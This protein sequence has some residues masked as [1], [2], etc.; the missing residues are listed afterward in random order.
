LRRRLG[1]TAGLL[2]LAG[3]G[4]AVASELRHRRTFLADPQ[5]RL[6]SSPLGGH[7]VPA[8]SADGTELHVEVFGTGDSPTFV[9]IPGWTEEL[10]IFD[11]VTRELLRRGF[12]VVSYDPRGQGSS[13]G[14]RELDQSIERYAEDLTAVLRA[15]CGGRDDVIVAG[16]S[17]GGMSLV[18]WAELVDVSAFVRAVALVSTG[19]SGLVDGLGLLTASIPLE[20]RRALLIP[21]LAG[22]QPMIAYSTPLSRAINRY[23]MFG[24][25]ATA[26]HIAFVE[27]MIWRMHG[28]LRA[29]AAVTMRDLDLSSA[30][31]R[32]NVPALV[33]VGD[34][35]RLTPPVHARRMVSAL[36][37]VAEF[38]LLKRTGHMVP[39][40]RPL[41]LAD[42]LVGL[43]QSVGMPAPESA[44]DRSAADKT[45]EPQ[46]AT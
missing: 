25:D 18:G 12:R 7:P 37:Q 32:V 38:V 43:A 33:V 9:L 45:A 13:G 35:D 5:W 2:T 23:V 39:V 21:L 20:T 6:L 14:G 8:R 44:A 28:K 26:A 30:L 31:A 46:P 36:P 19:M 4:V 1:A 40:E 29:A 27:P 17:M 41:E 15:T 3:A 34:G 10:Q 24:P 42:A 11:L 16:H 22:D